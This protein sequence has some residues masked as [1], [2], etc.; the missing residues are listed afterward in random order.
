MQL[1]KY[2]YVNGIE[3]PP[4]VWEP[5]RRGYVAM[6]PFTDSN[7]AYIAIGFKRETNK[8]FAEG[9]IADFR[10]WDSSKFAGANSIADMGNI[11]NNIYLDG[12]YY[13]RPGL[14]ETLATLPTN[15]SFKKESGSLWGCLFWTQYEPT[16]QDYSMGQTY[17]KLAVKDSNGFNDILRGIATD[18]RSTILGNSGLKLDKNR[19]YFHFTIIYKDRSVVAHPLID[20]TVF[21]DIWVT[22]IVPEKIYNYEISK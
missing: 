6:G 8:Q 1:E 11:I 15:K 13:D 3:D 19:D 2:Y 10:I 20:S 22:Y 12:R 16:Y 21:D 5:D 17:T 14:N 4:G 18:P 7:D 9:Y